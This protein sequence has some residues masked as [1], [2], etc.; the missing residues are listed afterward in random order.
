MMTAQSRAR[1][2]RNQIR[3]VNETEVKRKSR[4]NSAKDSA[5]QPQ[6]AP[7]AAENDTQQQIPGGKK[8]F[9]PGTRK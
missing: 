2:N 7:I 8:V 1:Q 4:T 3:Q 6:G 5:V 9:V